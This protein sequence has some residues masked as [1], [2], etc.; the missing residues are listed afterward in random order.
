MNRASLQKSATCVVTRPSSMYV[1]FRKM[2][3]LVARSRGRSL[4]AQSLNTLPKL[5]V[6]GLADL[7][8]ASA[9]C[10]TLSVFTYLFSVNESLR[11]IWELCNLAASWISVDR[12]AEA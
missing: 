5:R 2:E 7:A 1:R 6:D 12:A 10:L 11:P 3:M 8:N 4:F 9:L